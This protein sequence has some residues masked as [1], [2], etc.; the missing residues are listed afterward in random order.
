MR[1][2]RG[3]RVEAALNRKRQDLAGLPSQPDPIRSVSRHVHGSVRLGQGHHRAQSAASTE[4][5]SGR[6]VS[7]KQPR[8]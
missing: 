3:F 6:F 4:G 2:R 7:P 5:A 8:C 1:S